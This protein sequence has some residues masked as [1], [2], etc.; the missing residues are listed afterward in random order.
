MRRAHP[1]ALAW[2]SLQFHCWLG[3]SHLLPTAPSSRACP[4]QPPL[5]SPRTHPPPQTSHP[6]HTIAPAS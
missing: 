6:T 3:W 4:P 5:T 1:R 2:R